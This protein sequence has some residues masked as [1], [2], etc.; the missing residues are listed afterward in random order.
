VVAVHVCRADISASR[1]KTAEQTGRPENLVPRWVVLVEASTEAAIRAALNG[2]LG[3]DLFAGAPAVAPAWGVYRLQ[4]D[5]L[6]F[7]PL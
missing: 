4:F 2:P 6:G 1:T 7:K 3:P 5:I